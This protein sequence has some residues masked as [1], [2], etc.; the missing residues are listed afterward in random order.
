MNR[1]RKYLTDSSVVVNQ[2]AFARIRVLIA[3]TGDGTT[4]VLDFQ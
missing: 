2:L 4:E 1:I 3:E